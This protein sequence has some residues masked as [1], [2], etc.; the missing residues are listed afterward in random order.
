MTGF[1]ERC[2]E[3]V[4]LVVSADSTS[5]GLGDGLKKAAIPDDLE[6]FERRLLLPFANARFRDIW[7]LDQDRYQP[8][9]RNFRISKI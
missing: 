4:E 5:K 6:R 7:N 1:C 9:Y 8:R 3:S 2:C